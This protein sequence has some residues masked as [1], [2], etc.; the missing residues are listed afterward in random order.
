MSRSPARPS[1]KRS[2]P[3]RGGFDQRQTPEASSLALVAQGLPGLPGVSML[4]LTTDPEVEAFLAVNPVD[5]QAAARFR[6]LPVELQRMVLVRGSLV[7]TRDPSAVLMSRVR[8][9]MSGGGIGMPAQPLQ[10]QQQP[11]QPLVTFGSNSQVEGFLAE[12]PVDFQAAS[13]L[14]ALPEHLQRQVLIRGSLS[15]TR[16]PSSVM[17]S[18]IRDAMG[19][20]GTLGVAAAP[21][22]SPTPGGHTPPPNFRAG[23]WICPKCSF[24]NYSSRMMCTQCATPM[25]GV[26]K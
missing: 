23:D 19:G 26:A 17:M 3:A 8:D 24:H 14:R 12:N 1:P 16:D 2:K 9:A 10:L 22:P 4:S 13:R 18:R 21:M 5:Q 6:A 25:L 20:G 7:G 15:S 11:Q